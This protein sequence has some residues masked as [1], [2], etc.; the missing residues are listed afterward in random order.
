MKTTHFLLMLLL[1]T[2]ISIFALP[3][4]K[5]LNGWE[6]TQPETVY[7]TNLHEHINGQSPLYYELG[8]DSLF[9]LQYKKKN[10][11]IEMNIYKMQSPESAMA[12]YLVSAGNEIP[13][14]LFNE[15]NSVNPY[16]LNMVKGSYYFQ[17]NIYNGDETTLKDIRSIITP[18]LS[19]IKKQNIV[20]LNRL[21]QKDLV[22]G[23]ERIAR[24]MYSMRNIYYFGKGDPLMLDG[25]I[26]AVA[27][28]YDD[29]NKKYTQLI[30]EYPDIVQAKTVFDSLN[31]DTN[32]YWQIVLKQNNK[33]VFK[34]IYNRFGKVLLSQ[35]KITIN[36][37]L[38]N[39]PN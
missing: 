16:Q 4:K 33:L 30:I 13:S 15:R 17:I 14:D 25:N 28:E 35:N 36:T 2:S 12:I 19:K 8:F 6:Q 18:T 3:V 29:G 31:S 11:E 23:S 34:D 5:S 22:K 10:S 27:G 32:K 21:P 26:F 39:I 24:G 7:T 20:L 38:E 1:G 9:V 37:K